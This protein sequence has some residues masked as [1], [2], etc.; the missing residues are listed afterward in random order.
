MSSIKLALVDDEV[1]FREG[2]KLMINGF[3]RID[4]SMEAANGQEF[5][6][7]LAESQEHPDIVLM[8]M[9]MPVLNGVET[10]KILEK[11]YPNI[12]IIILSSY[13]SESFVFNML[14]LG[15]A[16][17]LPKNT[18][19]Q[20]VENTIRGVA[21]KG[22]Y[23]NSEVLQILREGIQRRDK[24]TKVSFAPK[25]TRRE[26]EILQLICEQYTNIEIATK[27]FISDRT[28]DGH[29]MNLLQK[30]GCRNT[31]GLVAFA[32]QH[33]LV[34]IDPSQFWK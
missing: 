32:I 23:Y 6:N 34:R 22:F 26:K 14:E 7:V 4:I 15:A 8:D 11:E 10:A 29:R 20:E 18:M 31:A 24:V 21:E 17:Y 27:L 30:L 2:I 3:D 25:I 12:K 28:V 33:Q 13:F 5:L 9:K 19:L 16:A 1:L